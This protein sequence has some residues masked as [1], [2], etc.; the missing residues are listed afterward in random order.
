MIHVYSESLLV[1]TYFNYLCITYVPFSDDQKLCMGVTWYLAC[2]FQ[3]FLFSPFVV[4]FMWKF[5]GSLVGIC[6]VAISCII[7]GGLTW[8]YNWPAFETTFYSHNA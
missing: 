4:W 3:M 6:V 1:Y 5:K 2:D 8:Y 7:P